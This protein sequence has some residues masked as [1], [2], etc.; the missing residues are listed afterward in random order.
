[1]TPGAEIRDGMVIGLGAHNPKGHAACVLAA[2]EALA[3]AGHQPRGDLLA[4]FGGGGMPTNRR[5]PDLPDAHGRGCSALVDALRPDQAVI[6]K[7]GWAVSW[8]EVGLTWFEVDVRGT[9]TYVGSRHLLPYRNAIADAGQLIGGLESWFE[10]WAEEKGDELIAPQG[11]VGAIA[12]G[13]P[14]MPAFTTDSCRFWVDLR[15]HPDTTPD[16]AAAAFGAEINRLATEIG[17]EVSWRQT[18]AIPGTR[19]PP[20]APIIRRAIAAWEALEGRPHQ[21]IP[22][23]SGA[24]DANILRANGVPTARIGLPKVAPPGTDVDFAFG[25]NAVAIADL[26]R[27]T[28]LLIHIA[29]SADAGPE[30]RATR[31]GP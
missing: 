30:T 11:V 14:S 17:A 16:D 4:G 22:R 31:V 5:R 27:L 23:L 19:T 21:P 3:R 1:M 25:M 24:T 7:S 9:H 10:R 18:V 29:V 20:D 26:E 15:L 2:V 6:A 8:A 12:G 28:K 13:W